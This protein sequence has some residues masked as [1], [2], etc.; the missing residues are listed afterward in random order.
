[1][2]RLGLGRLD[3]PQLRFLLR[4]FGLLIGMLLLWWFLLLD[5]LLGWVHQSGDFVLG[6]MPGAAEG[7]HAIVKPDGN[8]MLRL[9]VPE[10]AAGREDLQRLAGGGSPGAQPAKVRSFR[11]EITRTRVALFTVA[12]PLFWAL[13][14][15]APG[16][17]M[18]R[19]M[20]YGSAGIAAAM[21]FTLAL[22]GM[23]SI[24]TYFHI[25]STPFFA[26]LWTA[27]GYMNSEVLPYAMPIFLGLWLNRELRAQV[28]AWVPAGE[29]RPEGPPT[30]RERKRAR[31]EARA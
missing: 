12:M 26:F 4:A 20:A 1:M 25:Q 10:A 19:M 28:F 6:W 7:P 2:K 23:E 27:A 13:M 17:R 5:P 15:A 30:R 3:S 9:P 18:L 8:W 31:R 14:L 21:P 16:K 29:P 22:D 24:R 11:L